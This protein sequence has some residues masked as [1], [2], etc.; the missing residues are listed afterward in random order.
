MEDMKSKGRRLNWRQACEILGCGKTHFYRLIHNGNLPA[1]KMKG[2]KRGI[3][4]FEKD[5]IDQIEE[6]NS[7]Y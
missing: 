6:C 4:V 5:C 2:S 7:H 1:Y 3:W